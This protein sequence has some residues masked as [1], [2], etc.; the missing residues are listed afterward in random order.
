MSIGLAIAIYTT[1]VAFVSSIMVYYFGVMYPT[2][3]AKL[4]EKSK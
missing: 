3:E 2:E 1:I 4:K